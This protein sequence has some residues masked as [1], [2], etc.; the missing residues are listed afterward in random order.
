MNRIFLRGLPMLVTAGVLWG[1]QGGGQTPTTTPTPHPVPAAPGTQNAPPPPGGAQDS[2]PPQSSADMRKAA[3]AQAGQDASA[4]E[5]GQHLYQA[6]CSF[7]HG[8]NAKGGE[9]GP[10]LLRSVVVLHDENGNGIAPILHGSRVEKGM[11]KFPFTDEQIADVAAFLHQRVKAAAERGTYQILNIVTG[12][13]K[14]GERYFAANCTSCHS[15]SGDLAH[16]GSKYEPVEVQQHVVM[17]REFRWGRQGGAAMSPKLM[18]TAT[19]TLASGE[20]VKGMLLDIDDFTVA[21]VDSSG[22]RHVFSRDGDVPKVIVTDPM[23][24]HTNQLLKYTDT[25]IHNLTAYLVTLK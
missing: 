25:D 1:M 22:E 24:W 12:D 15:T 16:V 8:G 3:P 20:V 5:S 11:P 14:K 9:S 2:R 13:P 18:R 19:V 7:C 23:Q 17:P 4:V 21:V 6:N 10:D